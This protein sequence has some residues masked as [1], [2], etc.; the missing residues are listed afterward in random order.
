MRSNT[1]MFTFLAVLASPAFSQSGTVVERTFACSLI[2]GYT[3]Q[4][5]V[6]VMRSFEWDEDFAPRFV[7]LREA[8]YGSDEFREN[9][10]FV[11]SLYYTSMVE[12]SEKRLAFRSRNGGSEGYSLRDVAQC[13]N[14][15]RI[16]SVD[17]FPGQGSGGD[18][19]DFTAVMTTSCERNLEVPFS[20]VASSVTNLMGSS[21]RGL[22]IINRQFG[23]PTQAMGSRFGIRAVFNSA[24]GF[25]E[26]MDALRSN[27]PQ[28]IPP[29][30][31]P[32]AWLQYRIY[33]RGN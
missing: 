28:Q 5:A 10:D 16:N 2:N 21:L 19:P 22:Q 12:L 24:E 9:W 13:D 3:I 27:Q 33:D 25:S 18:A 14:A 32:S 29:C 6:E 31:I 30:N 15:P 26:S 17:F 23:G 7:A 1:I 11:V 20:T 4:D 8:A